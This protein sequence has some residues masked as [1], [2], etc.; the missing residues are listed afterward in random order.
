MFTCSLCKYSPLFVT[1][2]QTL[3]HMQRFPGTSRAPASIK[4][5]TRRR[6]CRMSEGFA[7]EYIYKMIEI[8]V[9]FLSRDSFSYE[10]YE[11]IFNR[12]IQ[13]SPLKQHKKDNCCFSIFFH[14]LQSNM[15][16]M[17]GEKFSSTVL[18][19]VVVCGCCCFKW[20]RIIF[21]QLD[22]CGIMMNISMQWGTHIVVPFV[23]MWLKL[24]QSWR[25][26]Q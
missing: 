25:F 12:G 23:C 19:V 24:C 26:G 2:Q 3:W 15:T 18:C 5:L 17:V 1:F 4:V 13:G 14:I 6:G 7:E 22:D 11:S 20:V 8:I 21:L 16:T 9:S 10:W